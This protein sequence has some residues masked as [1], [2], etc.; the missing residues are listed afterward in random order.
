MSEINK[1][2]RLKHVRQKLVTR[3][4]PFIHQ[5]QSPST[6][7]TLRAPGTDWANKGRKQQ[8]R[9]RCLPSGTR[10]PAKAPSVSRGHSTARE[11]REH[12]DTERG[13]D[14]GF[15]VREGRSTEL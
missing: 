9:T 1:G 14:L 13:T 15:R 12:G 7:H 4:H 11:A 2:G 5:N 6:G 8:H 3:L 10:S